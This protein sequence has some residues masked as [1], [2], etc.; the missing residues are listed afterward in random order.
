MAMAT[1]STKTAIKHFIVLVVAS[2]MVRAAF[3]AIHGMK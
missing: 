2:A 1:K 3:M